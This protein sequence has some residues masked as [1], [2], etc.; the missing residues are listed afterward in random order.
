VINSKVFVINLEKIKYS[1]EKSELSRP[2]SF[3]DA[4]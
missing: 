2:Q 3:T 1:K 4:M